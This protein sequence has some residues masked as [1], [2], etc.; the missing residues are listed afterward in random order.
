MRDRIPVGG[1][2]RAALVLAAACV[3]AFPAWAA[4]T[5]ALTAPGIPGVLREGAVIEVVKEGF[6]GTE[7]PLPQADGSLL[8]TENRAG[9]IV[10]VAPDGSTAV[11]LEETG[12]ANALALDLRGQVVAA[13]TTRPAIGIVRPG[14]APRV[15][16]SGFEGRAFNRPNDLVTGRLGQVYF[17]DPGANAA[18]GEPPPV[19]AVY[20]LDAQGVVRR[21]ASTAGR[22]NGIA[23]SPDERTLY[24]ADTTGEW[25]LAHDVDAQGAVSA[26]RRFARLAGFAQTDTGPRSGADGLAVDAAGRVYVASSAGVQVF[27]PGGQPLGVIA[28][29]KAPQN[30]AFAGHDRSTLYIVGRGSV[31]RVATLTRGPERPGK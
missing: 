10:R 28:L 17:T 29:P 24:L 9:R 11:W 2:G 13:L 14:A 12:G 18:P 26:E 3:V 27:T 22:P 19:V 21:I 20:H 30:L 6:D 16:A 4:E 23:L 8:F 7:G 31:Y 15:L 5:A 25:V 1:V